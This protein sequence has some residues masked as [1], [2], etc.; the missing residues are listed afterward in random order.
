MARFRCPECNVESDVAAKR[1]DEVVAVYCLRHKGGTDAHTRPVYMF[2]IK[3]PD[4]E[5]R[6]EYAFAGHQ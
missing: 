4:V 2:S 3:V 5:R 6:R 1:G